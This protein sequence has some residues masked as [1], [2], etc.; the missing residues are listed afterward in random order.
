MA[1]FNKILKLNFGNYLVSCLPRYINTVLFAFNDLTIV[2]P[3]RYIN[4]VLSFL[5]SD[6]NS[7]F[8][9]L[10]DL[11]AVDFPE[12]DKRFEVVYMLLSLKYN[13]R[14]RVKTHVNEMS[15]LDSVSNIYSSANWLERE[16]WDMFGISFRNHPDL[17]RLLT[18]YGFDGHPLRKDFPLNGYTA[19]RYDDT[20]KIVLYETTELA[21]EY[22]NFDF[23]SP[24]VTINR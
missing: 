24:W 18:D 6:L 15:S 17:R 5:K 12:N 10:V 11:T 22:R 23:Q 21:Q 16:V 1:N 9:V 2:V 14:I 13:T 4:R 20:Q 19:V 7:Q 3:S 8:R